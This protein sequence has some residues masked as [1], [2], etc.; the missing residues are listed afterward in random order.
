MKN[1]SVV[2]FLASAVCV[3]TASGIAVIALGKLI[4]DITGSEFDLGLLGLA[5]FA[6]A[7]VLVFVTGPI[8]DRHDRR[9]VVAIGATLE[10]V[11]MVALG[12]LALNDVSSTTP[13][14]LLVIGFGT[15]RAFMA[16]A[17]RALP[18][19]IVPP[20]ELATL[21]A[22]YAL[23]WQ[24]SLI[25]GPVIGG[26]LYAVDPA[27][28]FVGVAVL[29]LLGAGAVLT[30]EKDRTRSH[31]DD[32]EAPSLTDAFEGLRF[33]SRRPILLG[34]ISLDLF[35]VLF[36]GAV[37]LLPAIAEQRL[38]VGPVG[39]GWLRA[40]VGIGAGLTT[41]VLARRPL[42][43]RIGRT[44]LIAVAVFGVFTVVL[45]VT[46]EFAVAF[47]ALAIL[48]GADAV[49][50]YIRATLV[51]LATPADRRGRVLAVENV[52][53]GASNELGAF[54]SGAVAAASSTPVAI[55]SGGFATLIVAVVWWFRF[56]ALRDLDEFPR[57]QD[58]AVD[59]PGGVT[60]RGP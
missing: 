42:L 47:A 28:P 45:G 20:A 60:D 58:D 55:V 1:R 14:F 6:P 36:G 34:A 19:D 51:P 37:A 35:A 26:F 16:P 57:S 3:S 23:S 53:I 29:L 48:S 44:L 50:V 56:P 54:E 41:I 46:R 5:E 32:L 27:A 30:I 15:F 59:D 7:A 43:H 39:L 4:Y 12:S 17:A 22:R 38:G 52:F 31:H 49:S 9:R 25:I 40:A 21:V 18:S 11:T 24:V 10:A 8:A 13:I 2:A 33:I